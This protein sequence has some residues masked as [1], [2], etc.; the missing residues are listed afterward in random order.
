MSKISCIR[1]LCA[2]PDQLI[3]SAEEYLAQK[4]LQDA[5]PEAW[6]KV[7]KT[8]K[9]KKVKVPRPLGGSAYA[10]LLLKAGE[11]DGLDEAPKLDELCVDIDLVLAGK[12]PCCKHLPEAD[13]TSKIVVFSY[14]KL[15]LR[16]LERRYG[17]EM[18]VR[19]D[20]DMSLKVRNANKK[21]FQREAATRLF[22][23]SDAGGYGV[24]LPQANHLFNLDVPFTAGRVVQRNA[25]VRRANLDFHDA[26]HVSNYLIAHS[27]EVYY[28]DVTAQKQKVA[29]AVRTGLGTTQGSIK[30]S[31]ASLGQFL[32]TH[33]DDL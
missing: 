33:H 30:V 4:A 20:G 29:T 7:T 19:Y 8:I 27:L 5:N 26:V 12:C 3:G 25:R 28:A 22:L 1:M 21:R 6:P 13:R 16:I 17:S 32:R 9:G 18:A 2:H 23:T 11:L 24:D 31:A 14:H 15:A 10:A